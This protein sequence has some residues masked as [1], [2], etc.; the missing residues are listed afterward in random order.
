MYEGWNESDTL[1]EIQ[2]DL[3]HTIKCLSNSNKALF[4]NLH[5]KVCIWKWTNNQQRSTVVIEAEV[6]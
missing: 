1:N 3:N 4:A 2:L 6:N 5:L